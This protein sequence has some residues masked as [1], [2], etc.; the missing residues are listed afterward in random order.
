MIGVAFLGIG[1]ELLIIVY[2]LNT[3][4]LFK[5]TIIM[6]AVAIGACGLARLVDGYFILTMASG[7]IISHEI[8]IWA[9]DSMSAVVSFAAMI[10]MLPL[11]WNA[12]GGH[13]RIT[14]L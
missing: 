10:I 5:R 14:E 12:M 2:Y 11:V 7:P 4:L 13:C 6:F 8:M 1:L 3:T 9:F